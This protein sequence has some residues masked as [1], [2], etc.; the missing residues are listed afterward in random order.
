MGYLFP[1]T[2]GEHQPRHAL[3]PAGK[4]LWCGYNKATSENKNYDHKDSLPCDVMQQIRSIYQA[5]T[6]LDLLKKILHGHNQNQN[7]SFNNVVW[8]KIPKMENC[9]SP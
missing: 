9:K 4:D 3:C 8:A 2:L 1:Q 6:N 7:K 5:L